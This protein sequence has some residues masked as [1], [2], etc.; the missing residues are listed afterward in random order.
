MNSIIFLCAIIACAAARNIAP[1]GRVAEGKDAVRGEFPYQV[2]IQRVYTN[3]YMA[4]CGGAI[5]SPD[6]VLSA[7]HCFGEPDQTSNY[8]VVAGILNLNDVNVGEQIRNIKK[9]SNHELY[10]GNDVAAPHDIAVVELLDPLSYSATIKPALLPAPNQEYTGLA[11]LSGWGSTE[12]LVA[13]PNTLQYVDL[14]VI[15]IEECNDNINKAIFGTNPLDLENNVCTGSAAHEM[16][17]SGDSGG[18]LAINGTVIGVV[19]WGISGCGTDLNPPT[20]YVK[21]SKYI[22]WIGE[23]SSGVVPSAL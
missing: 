3:Q 17:C 10:P 13:Q 11:T 14:P 9:I 4:F 15:S 8:R 18:P 22:D 5:L 16:A 19:S 12:K 6:Y 1:G 21:V 2:S 7:A 23:H 20:V